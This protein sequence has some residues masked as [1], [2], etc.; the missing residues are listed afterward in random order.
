MPKRITDRLKIADVPN[1]ILAKTGVSRKKWVIYCWIRHGLYS[2]TK[3]RIYLKTE[4]I[5]NQLFT[6]QSWVD[7]FL[8]E[9]EE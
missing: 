5:L 8:R 9:I 7:D 3:K 1:Y 6:R 4:K 2:Y